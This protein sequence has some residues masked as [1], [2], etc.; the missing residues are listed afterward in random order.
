MSAD[1]HS[2]TDGL[3]LVLTL[4]FWNYAMDW[5]GYHFKAIDRLLEPPPLLLIKNGQMLRRNMRQELITVDELMAHLREEGVDDVNS[6]RA[7]YM[8][9][10]GQISVLRKESNGGENVRPRKK[11]S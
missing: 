3:L 7:A 10:D 1:Y 6:V 9:G 8:E 4:T 11:L 5:L 2:I